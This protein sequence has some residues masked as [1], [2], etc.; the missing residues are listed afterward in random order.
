MPNSVLCKYRHILATWAPKE[1]LELAELWRL[2][3]A[4]SSGVTAEGL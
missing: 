4:A 2:V 1:S 3:L